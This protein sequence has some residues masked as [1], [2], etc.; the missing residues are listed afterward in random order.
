[1]CVE[2]L[3]DKI[4]TSVHEIFSSMVMMDIVPGSPLRGEINP[5][6]STITGMIGLAGTHKGML[7]IHLPETLA[8]KVTGNFLGMA[9]EEIDNDVQDA[10]GELANMLGGSIKA[11]LSDNGK[12]I[13]LSMPSTIC[14]QEYRFQSH[15]EGESVIVPFAAEG[16]EFVVELRSKKE[17]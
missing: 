7:A 10:I 2:N 12:D 17:D 6:Q 3:P 9:V 8:K 11:I 1:M 14:G 15:Y 13:K 5:L 16:S 4:T